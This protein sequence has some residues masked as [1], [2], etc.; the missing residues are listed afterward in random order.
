MHLGHG[1]VQV[2]PL[3]RNSPSGPAP[4]RQDAHNRSRHLAGGGSFRQ[5]G[6]CPGLLRPTQFAQALQGLQFQFTIGKSGDRQRHGSRLAQ[7]AQGV[8][9]GTTHNRVGVRHQLQERLNC[10]A[11]PEFAGGGRSGP[12]D[13]HILIPEQRQHLLAS[14][15]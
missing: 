10:P 2:L 6:D 9:A 13:A 7:Q 15:G 14:L 4:R 12:P 8:E 11:H 1:A 3:S 5:F